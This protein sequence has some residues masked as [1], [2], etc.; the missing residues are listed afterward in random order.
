MSV[1]VSYINN[2]FVHVCSEAKQIGELHVTLSLEDW[3]PVATQNIV[4][5]EDSS[6]VIVTQ[7]F[8]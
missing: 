6:Q 8:I 7:S 4:V 5:G 3:G 2:D 1:L